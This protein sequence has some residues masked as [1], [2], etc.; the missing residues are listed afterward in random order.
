MRRGRGNRKIAA[1]VIAS[2]MALAM[3]ATLTVSSASQQQPNR[4]EVKKLFKSELS[5]VYHHVSSD[6]D[7]SSDIGSTTHPLST[8]YD[9]F[10]EGTTDQGKPVSF[11]VSRDKVIDFYIELKL[12]CSTGTTYIWSELG[13][14]IQ[15]S[16]FTISGTIYSYPY[17][18]KYTFNG[19]FISESEAQ[20][21]WYKDVGFCKGSGTWTAE[22]STPGFDTGE[23]TYPSIMGTHKGE[24]KPSH[25]ISVSKLYTYPCV[26]TGGHTK[27]IELY[28][29]TTLIA[30]GT[31]NGYQD[32]YHNISITPSVTLLAGHTYNYTIVTG[33]YPQIIHGKSKH[34]TRGTITCTLFV[35]ANGKR[36]NDLIPAIRLYYDEGEMPSPITARAINNSTK[37]QCAEEDNINIP[38]FGNI[39][40]FVVE[41]SHPTYEVDTYEC[42]PNFTNCPPPTGPNYSFTP[43]VSELFND[44]ETIVEAVRCETWWRPNGMTASVVNKSMND[45]HYIR[46]YRK[47]AD[48]NEWPQF[49]VLYMD[50][51]LRLIPQPPE[52]AH[53]VCFGSS[54]IIGPTVNTSPSSRPIAEITSVE[55]FSESEVVKVVYKEGGSA[56]ISLKEMNRKKACVQ[57]NVN[58]SIDK[59]P[60]ACFR[61]MFVTDGNADV[62]HVMWKDAL[63]NYHDDAIMA[64]HG[65]NGTEWFFYR[66]T[67]SCHNPSAPDI[68]IKLK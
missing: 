28:E 30:G 64:F 13:Y 61:S 6:A 35:D 2:I 32:D 36:Y 54:V 10:W 58:Y 18:K 17:D 42:K 12:T 16:N 67:K 9:G 66:S 20:G 1:I 59:L 56:I 55:Y 25:N 57:I 22:K 38:F 7:G 34:V 8:Q 29:N 50:G 19:T 3:V 47:V 5:T 40:S 51:N 49:F 48:A 62:D 44:G 15:N 46:I 45:T 37:T 14:P 26:G 53:S 23:G 60:F 33:S 4:D 63:G 41:A 24:I 52:E 31:W 11:N 65:G 27:S 39:P 68:H 21:T 43:K